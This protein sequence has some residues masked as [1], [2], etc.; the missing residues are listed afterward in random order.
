M[1]IKAAARNAARTFEE[2]GY[3]GAIMGIVG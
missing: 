2:F 1:L 3:N